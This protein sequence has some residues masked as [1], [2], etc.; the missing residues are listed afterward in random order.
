MTLYWHTMTQNNLRIPCLAK[1]MMLNVSRAIRGNAPDPVDQAGFF[2][3]YLD[4]NADAMAT[5]WVN[6]LDFITDYSRTR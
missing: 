2:I 4:D 6:V 1:F 3:L 5:D